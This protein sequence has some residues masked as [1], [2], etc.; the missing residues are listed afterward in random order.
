MVFKYVNGGSNSSRCKIAAV[1]HADSIISRSGKDEFHSYRQK[2]N[3]NR[4]L[5][6]IQ[7]EYQSPQ[8]LFYNYFVNLK[9]L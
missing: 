3:K 8:F 1:I 7:E 4:L 6:H 5:R 2:K 9:E